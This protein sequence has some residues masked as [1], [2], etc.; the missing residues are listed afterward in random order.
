[1]RFRNWV[2]TGLALVMA[3]PMFAGTYFG[4]LEDWTGLDY[5]YNDVAFSLSGNGL[6]LH[7]ATG[8]WFSAPLL[9]TSGTPFWNRSSLDAAMDNIGYCMYGGGNC[10]GGRALDAGAKYLATDST[11]TGTANDVIFSA[12]GQVTL[13]VALE[14]T[15]AKDSLGW[16]SVS[17][18]SAVHWLNA[19]S[20]TGLFSFTPDG[21]FGLV[22]Q[23]RTAIPGQ[24]FTYFSQSWYGSKDDVSHFAFFGGTDAADAAVAPEPAAV[25]L[26]PLGLL[27]MGLLIRRRKSI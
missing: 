12:S 23:S 5:D 14:I 18:P 22:G 20:S 17:N 24:G 6:M 1:M 3:S 26:M 21:E 9:G 16:Y 2:L 8:K 7:S 10:N 4:G 27:A 19:D 13:D 25:G 11:Q 15:A